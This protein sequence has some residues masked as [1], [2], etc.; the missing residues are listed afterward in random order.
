M[1]DT[2]LME[3]RKGFTLMEVLIVISILGI[4][5]TM[6]LPTY[7]KLYETYI[8]RTTAIKVK[9]LLNLGQELSIDESRR[10]C[11]EI[12][13]DKFRLREQDI[14]GKTIDTIILDK[15]IK[16]L[17]GSDYEVVYNRDGTSS[18][19]RFILGNTHGER[20]DIEVSIGTGRVRI[21]NRY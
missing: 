3:N 12:I 15:R 6:L 18:F 17:P 9:G 10:Y 13:N 11:I 2:D 1:A 21:I 8:L 5:S 16:I 19:A 4:L 20:T 7:S 14:L